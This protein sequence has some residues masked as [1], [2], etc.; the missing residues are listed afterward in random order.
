MYMQVMKY[1]RAML[2][3]LFE[4]FTRR[5]T[6]T[7]SFQY[8]HQSMKSNHHN[9]LS[10]G[11]KKAI[12]LVIADDHTLFRE[13]VRTV[14]ELNA[15]MHV[16][17]EAC[18]G[19]ELIELTEKKRPDIVITDIIMPVVDGIKA[20]REILIRRPATRVIAL[21]MLDR[22]EEIVQIMNAG[23][24]GF[25]SKSSKKTE[26]YAAIEAVAKNKLYI[27]EDIPR[28][29]VK[30]ISYSGFMAEG[31]Q[32][33][34][35]FNAM[36]LQVIH[37]ICMEKSSRD[38]AEAMHLSPRTVEW[39]RENIMGKLNVK[40]KVGIAIYAIRNGLFND[41]APVHERQ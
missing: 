7:L 34:P 10:A 5:T 2:N 37:H 14:I 21:S 39:Y 23:A 13:G 4:R 15:H 17:G 12:T 18:N 41:A 22:L 36:E 8:L 25:L 30:R 29:L 26:I 20:T 3:A 28:D 40:T 6:G 24:S 33:K 31:W 1:L 11:S 19:R 9:H 16:V 35:A 27:S 32:N 38:I